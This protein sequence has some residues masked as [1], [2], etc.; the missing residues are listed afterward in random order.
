MPGLFTDWSDL[1]ATGAQIA[2]S[3]K[4]QGS[5]FWSRGFRDEISYLVPA[6]NFIAFSNTVGGIAFLTG[7]LCSLGL[8][9]LP[10]RHPWFDQLYA[11]NLAWEYE[12]WDETNTSAPAN[13]T[14]FYK[15]IRARVEYATMQ[16]DIEGASAFLS[17]RYSQGGRTIPVPITAFQFATNSFPAHDVNFGPGAVT[18]SIT[19]HR[20]VNF[21]GDCWAPYVN[22]VNSTTWRNYPPYSVAF[23]G[24]DAAGRQT[25][26][27]VTTWDATFNFEITTPDITWL[28]GIKPDGTIAPLY[29]NGT[30]TPIMT[31]VDF[32]AV[33]GV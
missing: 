3:P 22:T 19:A 21:S 7:G 2:W 29:F 14:G 1:A 8:R 32:N 16:Y 11:N 27:T 12:G 15:Y 6:S 28:D 30:T 17:F 4:P 5:G 31:P 33:F 20:L 23:R 18:M 13:P 26:G 10:A 9:V 24:W 25:I